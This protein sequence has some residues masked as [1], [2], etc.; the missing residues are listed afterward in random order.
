MGTTK[1]ST[2]GRQSDECEGRSRDRR[3][4]RGGKVYAY[5]SSQERKIMKN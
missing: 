4:E 2:E 5:Q 3:K 1:A